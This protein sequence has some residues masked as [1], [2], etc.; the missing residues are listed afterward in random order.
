MKTL[1][2]NEILEVSG[3]FNPLALLVAGAIISA[4]DY[5]PCYDCYTEYSYY[6]PRY[7]YD[8]RDYPVEVCSYDYY[9][10]YDCYY[11]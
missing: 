7:S 11:I 6:E 2:N 5:D 1:S 8:Y 10:Y 4:L 3:G 9:G